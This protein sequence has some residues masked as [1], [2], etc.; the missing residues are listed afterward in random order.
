MK[1]DLYD[2][3]NLICKTSALNTGHR[4][5]F[6]LYFKRSLLCNQDLQEATILPC[7]VHIW[8]VLCDVLG[9]SFVLS[10]ANYSILC[11]YPPNVP[12][13]PFTFEV[14]SR[15]L[16]FLASVRRVQKQTGY[17]SF[18]LS[19]SCWPE[20]FTTYKFNTKQGSIFRFRSMSEMEDGCPVLISHASFYLFCIC[21]RLHVFTHIFR[22]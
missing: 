6:H 13:Q 11:D 10:K 20:H 7:K 12:S 8:H 5:W 22:L 18:S 21:L 17:S 16:V 1:S 15:R 4:S 9:D 2:F 19:F 14:L 3:D